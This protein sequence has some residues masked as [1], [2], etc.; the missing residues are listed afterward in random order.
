MSPTTKKHNLNLN[1]QLPKRGSASAAGYDLYSSEDTMIPAR[2]R[3]VAKTGLAIKVPYGTY[4]RV[5]PRSGLSVKFGIETGAGVVDRD[6]RG[7]V[8]VVL[9]NHEDKE[10]EIKKGDRIAQ[11]VLEKI[12]TPEI[13]IVDEL[14]VT[15]RGSGKFGSTGTR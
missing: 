13:E 9:F 12:V 6:Y 11:L 8:G 5:A 10:F 15:V 7:E 1:A 3:G 4:G 2:G 14:D